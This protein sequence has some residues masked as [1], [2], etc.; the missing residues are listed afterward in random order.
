M[1]ALLN[2]QA[3]EISSGLRDRLNREPVLE[4]TVHSVFKKAVN[5]VTADQDLVTLV[6]AGRP[7]M[8]MSLLVTPGLQGLDLKGG[9]RVDFK[10]GIF[11]LPGGTISTRLA[12]IRQTALPA[13]LDRT[14]GSGARS[15]AR[16]RQALMEEDRGG[17]A[18]LAA[19]LP[20]HEP[21]GGSGSLNSYCSFILKDLRL[22]LQAFGDGRLE[23]AGELAG[24]LVGF[25][26][27]LT[28]SCDDF[29]KG[30]L[31]SLFYD[32]GYGPNHPQAAG[33]F[34]RIKALA[35]DKTSLVSRHMLIQAA[36]GH[37]GTL[38]LELLKALADDDLVALEPL[39]RGLLS[40]G[41][42]SGADLLLGIYCAQT[43]M[44]GRIKYPAD[45][46]KQ[47]G[48]GERIPLATKTG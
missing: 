32:A 46:N 10:E 38:E 14:A 36:E 31:L 42:S 2:Y 8:P 9:Q 1:T 11:Y 22:F 48:G 7:L 24:S 27:G 20:D 26:P 15:L 3:V 33:F 43:W 44:P 29:L 41:A 25:G 23:R 16:I 39:I 30:V 18:C 45:H 21:A 34:E 37:G 17:I 6:A 5:L 12:R 28:P 4:F 35:K 19:F 47:A 40:I 13:P